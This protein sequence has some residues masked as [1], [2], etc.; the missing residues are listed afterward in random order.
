[1][2]EP[3][4]ASIPR[5][6]IHRITLTQLAVLMPSVVVLWLV[7]PAT[8]KAVLAGAMI[9]I[10]GRAYFGFYAFRFIGAQQSRQ[11]MRAFRQGELGKFV[12]VAVLFGGIFAA[13]KSLQPLMVF[14][15]YFAAWLLGT[16]ASMR[17]LR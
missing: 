1:M 6:P 9:E 3:Q 7:W 17:L 13:D 12:L 15:G 4:R 10:L 14:A 8:A 5:P 11:M 16:F 2:S